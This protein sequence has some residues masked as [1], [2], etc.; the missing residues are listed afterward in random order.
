M[1][2]VSVP[3]S[4][5]EPAYASPPRRGPCGTGAGEE[6]VYLQQGLA[7]F[8][9]LPV[10]HEQGPNHAARRRD[11]LG[12]EAQGLDVPDHLPLRD[13]CAGRQR[14]GLARAEHPHE[15][16][17]VTTTPASADGADLCLAGGEGAAAGRAP[18][19]VPFVEARGRGAR[20][21]AA[22]GDKGRRTRRVAPFAP[23]ADDRISISARRGESF[24]TATSASICSWFK[25]ALPF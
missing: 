18:P 16:A 14:A 21:G 23:A 9:G 24:R 11:A 22:A 19:E 1:A 4:C 7:V 20:G 8:D 5:A 6:G 3:G 12:E 15:P 25:D 2:L 13:S 10:L 17:V